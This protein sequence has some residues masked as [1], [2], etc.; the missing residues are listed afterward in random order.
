VSV[1]TTGPATRSRTGTPR[2]VATL[3]GFDSDRCAAGRGTPAAKA[4]RPWRELAAARLGP[5]VDLAS[6]RP[7]ECARFDLMR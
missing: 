6:S 5:D 2:G 7:P 1:N 3:A 4:A